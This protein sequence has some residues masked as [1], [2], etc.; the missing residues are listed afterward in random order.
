M[1]IH[2][3]LLLLLALPVLPA[4]DL[5]GNLSIVLPATPAPE[6]TKAAATLQEHIRKITGATLPMHSEKESGISGNAVYIGKTAALPAE[7][8]Q[9]LQ[10]ERKILPGDSGND[11]YVMGERGGSLFLCGYRPDGTLFAVYDFLERLGC[12]WYFACEAG[13]VIPAIPRISISI[14]DTLQVPAFSNRIH[15][16]WGRQDKENTAMETE[17]KIANRMNAFDLKGFSGHNFRGIWPKKKYPE[18]FPEVPGKETTYQVCISNPKT[19][20]TGAQWAFEQMEKKPGN[21]IITVAPND[22]YGHCECENCLKLGNLADRNIFLA[23]K[24]GERFFPRYPDKMIMIW[25]YAGGAQ[26][27]PTLKADGFDQNQDRVIVNIYEFFTPIPLIELID[28]WKNSSHYIEVTS[29]FYSFHHNYGAVH[30]PFWRDLDDKYR[31]IHAHGALMMRTQCVSDWASSGLARYISARLMWDPEQNVDGILRDFAKKM[32]PNAANEAYNLALLFKYSQ[33]DISYH[34]FMTHAL[35]LLNRMKDKIKTPE[36]RLR[37]DFYAAWLTYCH[38]VDTLGD[39]ITRPAEKVKEIQL[40]LAARLKR[41]AHYQALE[42]YRRLNYLNIRILEHHAKIPRAEG[43][44]LLNE[45]P[46]APMTHD[47]LAVL[48]EEAR[49]TW[50]EPAFLHEK[51]AFPE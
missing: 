2:L 3:L 22:G 23:N 49:R 12:R 10:F 9:K 15:Y 4:I 50:P 46:A 28:A 19:W 29:S 8:A 18:L 37:W 48:V 36:E 30:K 34:E 16:G 33:G 11:A 21:D 32:F 25:A 31:E 35:S 6:E 24:I 27:K 38:L 44:K 40:K 7:L 43:W 20:E 14:P 13:I 5:P 39:K 1:K 45:L 47:E 17:W 26:V 51:I 41:I 42:T